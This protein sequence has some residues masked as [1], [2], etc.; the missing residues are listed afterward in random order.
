MMRRIGW[1]F[2]PFCF[3]N[4]DFRAPQLTF[5][6]DIVVV[7]LSLLLLRNASCFARKKDNGDNPA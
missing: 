7:V 1:K 6:Y 3:S 2:D 4:G 5:A